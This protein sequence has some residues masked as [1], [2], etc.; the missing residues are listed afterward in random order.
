MPEG[1]RILPFLSND[2]RIYFFFRKMVK[3][4]SKLVQF[5]IFLLLYFT[6][7]SFIQPTLLGVQYVRED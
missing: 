1:F 6:L 2:Q 5:N 3:G 7:F 4:N